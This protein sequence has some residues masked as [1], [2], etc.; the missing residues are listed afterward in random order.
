MEASEPKTHYQKY[1]STIDGW[2]KAN[3]ERQREHN[4]RYRAKNKERNRLY[5][6]EY[7]KKKKIQLFA[8]EVVDGSLSPIEPLN[9][10]L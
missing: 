6:A 2:K 3:R 9:I 4:A 10:P 7:R 5:Q 1:K 8:V